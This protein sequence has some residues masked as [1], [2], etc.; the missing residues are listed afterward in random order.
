MAKQIKRFNHTVFDDFFK[1]NPDFELN[2]IDIIASKSL[3]NLKYF[4]IPLR[5]DPGTLRHYLFDIIFKEHNN[6]D[7]TNTFYLVNKLE[8][9]SLKIFSYI[10]A[11]RH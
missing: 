7:I 1:E 11:D 9:S 2:L 6:F 10:W 5:L 4:I 3:R 8:I